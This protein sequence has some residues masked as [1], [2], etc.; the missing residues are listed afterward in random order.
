MSD[1]APKV[2]LFVQSRGNIARLQKLVRE[3]AKDSTQ[4]RVTFPGLGQGEWSD[5]SDHDVHKLL[6]DCTLQRSLVRKGELEWIV[7]AQGT[8]NGA[9]LIA[10]TVIVAETWLVVTGVERV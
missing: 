2:V 9:T 7:R 8:V 3:L 10:V 1:D 5:V 6:R 4:V